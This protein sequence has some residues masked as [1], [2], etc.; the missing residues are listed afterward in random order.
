MKGLLKILIVLIVLGGAGYG[1]FLYWKKMEDAK[2]AASTPPPV[3][4]LPPPAPATAA[5]APGAATPPAAG[6]YDLT[7]QPDGMSKAVA[8]LTMENGAVVKV[9]FFPQDA[10]NTVKRIAELIAQGF[11]NGIVVHRVVPGFVVQAG[12]PTGTGAGGSGV[13]L[14]A[15]FNSRKHEP[16]ILSMARTDDPD[17]ADSQ[18]FIMLGASPQL[19]GKYTIFGKVIEGFDNVPKIKQGE[20]I[21]TFTIQ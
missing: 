21:K 16:G 12:D 10:P 17:S 6:A 8:T 3:E 14:K 9:R 20:K 15:E 2:L 18:F 7:V 1:G 13:K 5:P 19:D 11:Y 4:A